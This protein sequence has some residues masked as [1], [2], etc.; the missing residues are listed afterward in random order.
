M[1]LLRDL[2]AAGVDGADDDGR[3]H[4][5]GD[6]AME[7]S[8]FGPVLAAHE[9]PGVRG[10]D[11]VGRDPGASVLDE[12]LHAAGRAVF[13]DGDGGVGGAGDADARLAQQAFELG[14][15][16]GRG[17]VEVGLD[18]ELGDGGGEVHGGA[19]AE[20]EG[21]VAGNV[22]LRF[23]SRAHG[24][25][26]VVGHV[27]VDGLPETH[28]PVRPGGGPQ[29]GVG[30]GAS[31]LVRRFLRRLRVIGGRLL[32]RLLRARSVRR[33]PVRVVGR[34][35]VLLR[36]RGGGA[37]AGGVALVV[38]ETRVV[39]GGVAHAAVDALGVGVGPVA[40]DGRI[41]DAGGDPRRGAAVVAVPDIPAEGIAEGV[42]G[43]VVPVE[44]G[45]LVVG[46]EVGVVRVPEAVVGPDG[47][48][49]VFE[50]GGVAPARDGAGV[51]VP[52]VREDARGLGDVEEEVRA[53]ERLL[54]VRVA[55]VVGHAAR[56]LAEAEAAIEGAHDGADAAVGDVAVGVLEQRL[57]PHDRLEQG[58]GDAEA[59][60]GL[61]ADAVVPRASEQAGIV[62]AVG[63]ARGGGG[64][65]EGLALGGELDGGEVEAE[66]VVGLD[67]LE[68]EGV[69]ALALV[70]ARAVFPPGEEHHDQGRRHGQR[71]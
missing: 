29:P 40:V 33:L 12:H 63:L 9:D 21:V 37:G 5:D 8:E 19:A 3:L 60:V 52:L 10:L 26:G 13:G 61:L 30:G 71:R 34:V 66:V 49:P 17:G 50:E 44:P 6:A 4:A 70:R 59:G 41:A 39:F 38:E 23:E 48:V 68:G 56:D 46:V 53:D 15:V 35:R 27:H 28:D 18:A 1:A 20:P 2:L 58:G 43:V 64:G 57:D 11:A 14:G 54:G 62:E 67:S 55:G 42:V 16:G 47:V 25:D 51:V 24:V 65:G 32:V 31:R 69:A 7:A 45:V 22:V 36:G